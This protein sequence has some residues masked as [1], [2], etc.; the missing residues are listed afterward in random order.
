VV[1][2]MSG[3]DFNTSHLSEN[4]FTHPVILEPRESIEG[5]QM[6]PSTFDFYNVPQLIG[7]FYNFFN[8]KEVNKLF[9]FI[10]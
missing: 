8:L 1:S 5:L 10:R 9:C 6:V 3:P 7:I 4:G 2:R